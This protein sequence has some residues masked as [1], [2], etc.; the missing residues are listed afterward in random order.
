MEPNEFFF[1]NFTRVVGFG[2]LRTSDTIDR[3]VL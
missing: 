1:D 3:E 2:C